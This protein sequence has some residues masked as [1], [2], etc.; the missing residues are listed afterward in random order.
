[1]GGAVRV[2]RSIS[3]VPNE[4]FISMAAKTTKAAPRRKSKSQRIHTRRLKEEARK[5]RTVY[6]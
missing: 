4:E 5:T 6:K 2:G 1:M 3:H